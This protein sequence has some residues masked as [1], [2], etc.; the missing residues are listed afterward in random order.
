[1]YRYLFVLLPL[2][3]A[4]G[5]NDGGDKS[6]PTKDT[7]SV[8]P[9]DIDTFSVS[10]QPPPPPPPASEPPGV[11]L[12]RLN[13]KAGDTLRSPALISGEAPGA[14][15]FE[16]EF[17]LRLYDSAQ[18]LLG[19]VPARAKGEWMK[20]GFVPF[21]G[22]LSWKKYSGPGTLVYEAANPSGDAEREKKIEIRVW[23]R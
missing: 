16:A 14:W 13:Q 21:S 23:L 20:E 2:L 22:T 3:A 18:H 9:A 11:A 12:L 15:Y 1:M 19:M 7:V 4:C 6:G 8:G 17:L 10:A 5:S